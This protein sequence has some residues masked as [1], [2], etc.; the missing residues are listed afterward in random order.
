[1]DE[2][3]KLCGW[4]VLLS[5]GTFGCT[6]HEIMPQQR[7]LPQPNPDRPS[8]LKSS[9]LFSAKGS[10]GR[11]PPRSEIPPV[12]EKS[13]GLKPETDAA[14]ADAD[15]DAAFSPNRSA[16]QRDA[17]LDRARLRYQTALKKDPKSKPALLGLARMYAKSGDKE[18]AAETLQLAIR[19][20]PE[21]HEL[22]F[23]LGTMYAQFA[24][25]PAAIAACEKALQRDPENRTYLKTLGY[26]QAV[27]GQWESA[28][29]TMLRIMPEA[30]ARY[31]LGRVLLD[32]EQVEAAKSQ[33]EL[34]LRAN[35]DHAL[36][37]QYLRRLC[38]EAPPPS[39]ELLP[40]EQTQPQTG[41]DQV[42]LTPPSSIGARQPQLLPGT[43]Q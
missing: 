18:R 35:P 31:F 22:L 25:W 29:A 13:E 9:N 34:A 6:R 1:M 38:G 17:L 7:G 36:A 16:V 27:S 19:Y 15:V 5:L 42:P 4:I 41:N 43:V 8:L 32:L 33:M 11:N 14:F 28:F 39:G 20:H 24:D 2:L 26:C 10:D 23:R 12:R 30:D 37:Q 3:R 21:D 40:A